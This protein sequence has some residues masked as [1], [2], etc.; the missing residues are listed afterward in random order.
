MK[1]D[2]AITRVIVPM[3]AV[4]TVASLHLARSRPATLRGSVQPARPAQPANPNECY[5]RVTET[6]GWLE[7]ECQ[8]PCAQ[9]CEEFTTTLGGNVTISFCACEDEEPSGCC[10]IGLIRA[11]QV[12]TGTAVRGKCSAQ[13]TSCALGSD[14]V[15]SSIE[16]PDDTIIHLANCV[17]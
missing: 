15:T 12:P 11:G 5:G 6:G 1:R 17:D 2:R 10:D 4:G 3:L 16:F 7:L 14:C 13:D 9:G 8:N